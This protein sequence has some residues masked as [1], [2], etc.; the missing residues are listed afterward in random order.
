MERWRA[1]PVDDRA[2]AQLWDS[3]RLIVTTIRVITAGSME[4]VPR[5]S[6]Y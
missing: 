2:P 1:T 4:D 5:K 3:R 6:S